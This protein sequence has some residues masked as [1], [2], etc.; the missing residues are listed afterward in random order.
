MN[1]ENIP[2]PRARRRKGETARAA[3]GQA[4]IYVRVSTDEQVESGSIESQTAAC[5][6]LCAARGLEVTGVYVENGQSGG[7]LDRPVLSELRAAVAAGTIGVVIIYAIDRLS[8]S[9][10]DL[11]TLLEE[12]ANAGAGIA[13]ASQPFET[14]TAM[15]RAMIGLL[16]IFAELQRSEIRER[17]RVECAWLLALAQGPA[18]KALSKLPGDAQEWLKRH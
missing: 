1:I 7:K 9:Q 13:S 3:V 18:G 11:L 4:A 17:T 14:T 2:P 15:G 10:G 16:V 6:S 8:R 12:F 5:R